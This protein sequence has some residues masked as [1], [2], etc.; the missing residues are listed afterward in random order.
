MKAEIFGIAEYVRIFEKRLC[1]VGVFDVIHSPEFPFVMHAFG[2][3]GKLVAEKA[4]YGKRIELTVDV[5]KEKKRKVEH[6]LPVTVSFQN[7]TGLGRPKHVMAINVMG[8][9]FKTPGMY[10]IELKYKGK[11]IASTDLLVE[12]KNGAKQPRARGKKKK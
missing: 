2:I 3:G 11:V 12:K 7:R 9:L 6:Q 8:L 4:D 10:K 1:I 5:R